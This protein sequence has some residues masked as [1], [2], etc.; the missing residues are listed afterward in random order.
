M[1]RTSSYFH[2]RY[3]YYGLVLLAVV[4]VLG[5]AMYNA[6]SASQERR[7][8]EWVGQMQRVQAAI[9]DVVAEYAETESSGL[10][11]VLG[12]RDEALSRY[13]ESQTKLD[14]NMRRVIA[15]VSETTEQAEE[16]QSL[17]DELDRRQ[18][19]MDRLIETVRTDGLEVASEV[20]RRGGDVEFDDQVRWLASRLQHEEARRLNERQQQ[21]DA[22]I[23]QKNATLWL[24]NGL[25]LVAGIIGILAIGHSR[26]AQED[27]RLAELRAE[28][29]MHASAAKS[30]FL[31][32]MSHEIRTPM[33]ALYGYSELLAKTP[34]SPRARE[35]IR[36]IQTS[37]EA[38]MAL[39]NDILDL[40][41]IEAGKL[42]LDPEPVEVRGL[43]DSTLAVF[44]QPAATKQLQL[45]GHVAPAVPHALM[46][47]SARLRQV[48]MN[49]VS[50]AVKYTDVG[51]VRLSIHSVAG[52]DEE[53]VHL[54]I[55][56]SDT[57]I[58]MDA[59]KQRRLFE[60]FYRGDEDAI[61][62]REG[63]GLGLAIVRKLL[64]LMNGKV[65]VKSEPGRGSAFRVTLS[66]VPIAEGVA[67]EDGLSSDDIDFDRLAPSRVLI[68]DDVA[69]NRDLL[70]AYIGS[71]VHVIETAA[72]GEEALHRARDFEPDIV[73]MDLRMPRM[74][75]RTATARI[76]SEAGEAAPQVVAVTASSLQDRSDAANE[77]FDGYLRKPVSRRALFEALRELRGEAEESELIETTVNDQLANA[78]ASEAIDR[79]QAMA[80]LRLIVEQD[81]DEVTA[82][83][84]V[85]A[86]RTLAG[87]LLRLGDLGGFDRIRRFG[88]RLRA[89]ADRF[90]VVTMES[91][92]RQLPDYVADI[93]A[94]DDNAGAQR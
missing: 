53:H 65:S 36:A 74:D 8:T 5:A 62:E 28:Q 66:D 48:L 7:A 44:T 90:D 46:L 1:I 11:Y 52:S 12:G 89:A 6:F 55:E 94:N 16:L 14:D 29:A 57:G 13:T 25:A 85:R 50:N 87:E 59:D 71:D 68:V 24:M 47:D 32:S 17:A 27:Q 75:G 76:R 81:L 60:P 30:A 22:V 34:D 54:V 35:Y 63:T 37:G 23:T 72:D 43:M 20:V 88:Q 78:D 10:R 15:L 33:N 67:S 56:V 21:L 18:Q 58:G 93:E 41:R 77:I 19:H 38:L 40:S 92:L 84:R 86:V 4:L 69:W 82:S 49:L 39:I 26:R 80:G 79:Q 70:A 64:E 61:A 91:L 31:A 73:L 83:L 51:A 42:A 2:T 9:N 45:S 3:L